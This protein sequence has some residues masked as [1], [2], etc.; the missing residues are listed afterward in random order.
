[1]TAVVALK[2]AGFG[3]TAENCGFVGADLAVNVESA[4]DGNGFV[5]GYVAGACGTEVDAAK[6][7]DLSAFLQAVALRKFGG[8][9]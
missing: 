7:V 4:A 9:R 2:F 1:M 6:V 5:A 3:L 8:L